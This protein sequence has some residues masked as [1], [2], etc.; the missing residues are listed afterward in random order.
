MDSL[1]DEGQTSQLQAMMASLPTEDPPRPSTSGQ[2]V[3]PTS[4]HT[5]D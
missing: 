5:T 2:S 1:G 4:T 3:N